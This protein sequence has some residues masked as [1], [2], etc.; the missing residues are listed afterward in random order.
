LA[1]SILRT[2]ILQVQSFFFF[3]HATV[4]FSCLESF[5]FFLNWDFFCVFMA[6]LVFWFF[7]TNFFISLKLLLMGGSDGCLLA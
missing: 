7:P 6:K 1:A 3:L 4:F 2:E 5:F